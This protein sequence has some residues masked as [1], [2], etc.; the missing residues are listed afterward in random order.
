MSEV[1]ARIL[2]WGIEGAGK[3]ATLAMI[4]KKLRPDLRGELRREA[5]RLDPTIYFETL[6]ITIGEIGDLSMRLEVC[7]VPGAPDQAMTRK[8]LLD[9]V[10]GIVIVLDASPDR[11]DANYAAIDELRAS[12]AA[13]GR[14][15]DA[16]PI[17]LQ[18]NKRDIADPFAIEELHR[19]IGLDQAAVF[20]TIATTGHGILATLTTISKHVVRSRRAESG[21]TGPAPADSAATTP[22]PASSSGTGTG[23]GTATAST[24]ASTTAPTITPEA[25]PESIREP[26]TEIADSTSLSHEILEAAILAEADSQDPDPISELIEM[27]VATRAQPDWN[28]TSGTATK[29]TGGFGADL[30]IVSIGQASLESDGGVRLPLVLGDESG[31]T[32]TV[33]LSL[34]L[35][36]LLPG[37]EN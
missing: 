20:E 13:Y 28:A 15:L 9:E 27:D 30:R 5:T 6:S 1:N 29:P 34:K 19:R 26:A 2:L 7:A 24:R 11:I 21:Q 32:R 33:V 25:T 8:Q 36:A 31:Q 10:D 14:R 35:D 22:A 3:S 37:G 16:F 12:L 17:V 23:T 18:Y 4:H